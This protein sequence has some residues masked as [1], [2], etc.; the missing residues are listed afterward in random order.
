M[1]QTPTHRER[2]WSTSHREFVNTMPLLNFFL[3]GEQKVHC[4]NR[5]HNLPLPHIHSDFINFLLQSLLLNY[6]SHVV[7]YAHCWL[8]N[9]NSWCEVD[10]TLSPRV[11][12]W[13][14]RLLVASSQ[15]SILYFW[16]VEQSVPIILCCCCCCCWNFS[17]NSKM[18]RLHK[19]QIIMWVLSNA[20][21]SCIP[22]SHIITWI[23]MSYDHP[24]ECRI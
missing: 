16:W 18:P 7:K 1:G 3:V 5:W 23:R 15:Y 10:Q 4:A 20:H 22:T 17:F 11:R 14:T 24:R 6:C 8:C 19:V 12:V 2:V 9:M 13:P 21:T